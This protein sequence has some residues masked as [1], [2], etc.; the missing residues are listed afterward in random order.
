MKIGTVLQN[1][2]QAALAKLD[3]G[4]VC[5][6]AVCEAKG[7]A[8]REAGA[9][10]L[11]YK[12]HI[13]GSIG[14]GELEF[15]A[16]KTARKDIPETAF[17][18]E[19]RSYPLGPA[20]GQCC[21]GHVKLMFE[22]YGPSS[23]SVL[24]QLAAQKHGYS[25]HPATAQDNP[26]IAIHPS[27]EM[28]CLPLGAHQQPVFLYGAGHVGRAVVQIARHLPCQIYWVDTDATVVALFLHVLRDDC[29]VRACRILGDDAR[30][31]DQQQQHENH[32]RREGV[33]DQRKQEADSPLFGSVV[34]VQFD[35]LLHSTLDAKDGSKKRCPSGDFKADHHAHKDD[36]GSDGHGDVV[37]Q[38]D[39]RE[40]RNREERQVHV[41]DVGGIDRLVEVGEPRARFVEEFGRPTEDKE[42]PEPGMERLNQRSDGWFNCKGI[43]SLSHPPSFVNVRGFEHLT[44]DEPHHS[45]HGR[46][47]GDGDSNAV[48]GRKVVLLG[49]DH[50]VSKQKV[51]HVAWK[52]PPHPHFSKSPRLEQ[53]VVERKKERWEQKKAHAVA[54][55][56]YRTRYLD[57]FTIGMATYVREH[58]RQKNGI[59]QEVVDE[60]KV[61]VRHVFVSGKEF[62][63]PSGCTQRFKDAKEENVGPK[64]QRNSKSRKAFFDVNAP[65]SLSK[66]ERCTHP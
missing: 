27:E 11:V 29:E 12:N 1:W 66:S 7:S 57:N 44:T 45:Q 53:H 13:D 2:A 35:D 64:Q 26:I 62:E 23:Q 8:P 56:Q 41:D 42:A 50:Q 3:E 17:A 63:Q 37:P 38:T 25:L 31:D 59:N 9:A 10:M 49:C 36:D 34:G 18:R 39:Q 52:L 55:P 32:P 61:T 24:A 51:E 60:P 54:N 5:L 30:S 43:V 58:G 47:D 6:V 22:W 14:G 15:Q 46:D 16:I 33:K 20:L 40:E 65:G 4:Y 28:L 19:V 48:D 21:G